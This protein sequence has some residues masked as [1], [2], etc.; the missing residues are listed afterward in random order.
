MD[1]ECLRP[2]GHEQRALVWPRHQESVRD[3]PNSDQEGRPI[4]RAERSGDTPAL[5]VLQRASNACGNDARPPKRQDRAPLQVLVRRAHLGRID[6]VR[7]RGHSTRLALRADRGRLCLISATSSADHPRGNEEGALERA[8]RTERETVPFRRQLPS[9]TMAS[10]Q[11][12]G[13]LFDIGL[14]DGI[15]PQ[16]AIPEAGVPNG[17]RAGS[18]SWRTGR[19]APGG[20]RNKN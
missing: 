15:V 10:E 5:P 18:G 17:A 9:R 4:A 14:M 19:G 1:H 2:V 20:R 12:E 16:L 3:G 11:S 6:V 8:G 7:C 13:M